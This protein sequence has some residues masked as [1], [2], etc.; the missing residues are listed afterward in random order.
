MSST[1]QNEWKHILC[2]VAFV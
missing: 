2:A 1:G